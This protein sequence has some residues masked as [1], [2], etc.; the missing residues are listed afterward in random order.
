[1]QDLPTFDPVT[2]L[3]IPALIALLPAA[4]ALWT[5]RRLLDLAEDAAFAERLLAQRTRSGVVSGVCSVLL[6]A[7]AWDHVAWALP[8]LIATRLA[9]GYRI[10]KALY[11][12][13]WGFG[14][15]L[16]FF[17]RLV[18]VAF[19]FWVAV[20]ALPVIAMMAGS[21]DWMVAGALAVILGSWA[22]AYG[23]V[24]CTVLRAEPV[25]DPAIVARFAQMVTQC[26]LSNVILKQVDMRGGLFAN[27]VALPSASHP[28]V[29]VSS[30]LL[31]RLD[32]E[33]TTGILAHELAH[34]EHY[35]RSSFRHYS[36]ELLGEPGPVV[37]GSGM[38][39]KSRKTFLVSVI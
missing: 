6:L 15:Y 5:G 38:S 1:V 34:I 30:T 12:E 19:G 28:T 22:A 2:P 32:A 8:L 23:R 31:Q 37:P 21:R 27:A 25:G 3:L 9:V 11:R 16:S 20:G 26:G 17:S 24:F 18:V 39:Q 36:D 10:R 14:G 7:V 29:L 35:T 33:E 4:F 13:T